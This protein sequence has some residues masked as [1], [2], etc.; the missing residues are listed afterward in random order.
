MAE[1]EKITKLDASRLIDLGERIKDAKEKFKIYELASSEKKTK[2]AMEARE[3]AAKLTTTY[4]NSSSEEQ[5]RMDKE[6]EEFKNYIQK[7]A[8]SKDK[9]K[10]RR[11]AQQRSFVNGGKGIQIRL[12]SYFPEGKPASERQLD[13]IRSLYCT[14][15]QPT[16]AASLTQR[17]QGIVPCVRRP[18]VLRF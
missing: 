13:Y 4:Q 3:Q 15:M 11:L 5:K 8:D 16:M 14:T 17:R 9:E 10:Q 12:D 7:I 18:C 1:S 6:F 2:K